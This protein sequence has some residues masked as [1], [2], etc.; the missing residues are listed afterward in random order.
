MKFKFLILFECKLL[1][2]LTVHSCSLRSTLKDCLLSENSIPALLFSIL[3]AAF[4]ITAWIILRKFIFKYKS[5]GSLLENNL[6]GVKNALEYI[7]L[8][9]IAK[10]LFFL[11]VKGCFIGDNKIYSFLIRNFIVLCLEIIAIT[12]EILVLEVQVPIKNSDSIKLSIT[13]NSF[14]RC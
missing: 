3:E 14:I 12:L 9:H 11:S 8:F 13:I 4:T 5:N 1:L 2:P 6:V 7:L 10:G